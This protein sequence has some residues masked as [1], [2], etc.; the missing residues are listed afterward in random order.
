VLTFELHFPFANRF[1]FVGWEIAQV[2]IF[3]VVVGSDA[4]CRQS[5]ACV[6]ST[7]GSIWTSWK[8]Y[9][10]ISTLMTHISKCANYIID[11]QTLYI[12]LLSLFSWDIYTQEH[13]HNVHTLIN[14]FCQ[15]LI[16]DSPIISLSVLPFMEYYK[17]FFFS[18]CH[19][20]ETF[21]VN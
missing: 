14:Q 3:K 16:S 10:L 15:N 9:F 4:E 5:S 7:K 17:S 20:W 8:K 12:V 6:T 21:L 13:V 1:H 2:I 18:L 11:L 19:T